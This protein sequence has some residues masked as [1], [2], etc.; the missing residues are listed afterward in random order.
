MIQKY[1]RKTRMDIYSKP[2]NAKRCG[3]FNSN[4]PKNCI[5]LSLKKI[6][7][8][9]NLSKIFEINSFTNKSRKPQQLL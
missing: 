8:L 4:H 3:P 6:K 5:K 9:A 1:G 7:N 2:T